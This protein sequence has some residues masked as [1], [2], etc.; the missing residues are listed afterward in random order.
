[1]R[2][3]SSLE[4]MDGWT[5]ETADA[6]IFSVEAPQLDSDHRINVVG[7]A[8][9]D[10]V[11]DLLVRDT[12]HE[13]RLRFPVEVRQPDRAQLIAH[14]M[15]IIG[16]SEAE[17]TVG[18]VRLLDKGTATFLVRYYKGTQ[19]LYGNGTLGVEAATGVVA[20]TPRTFLFEDRDWLQVTPS[21]SMSGNTSLGLLVNGVHFVDVPLISV[22]ASE[23]TSVRI[24]GADESHA[25]KGRQL[26]A[27]AQAYDGASRP[28]W[29]VDYK[30]QLDG[31]TQ[32]GLGDLYR[33]TFDP[34]LPK[35]LSAQFGPLSA[36]AMIH[37][38]QGYVDSSN[39]L[40]CEL[41][42][43]ARGPTAATVAMLLALIA[44]LVRRRLS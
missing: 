35:M 32:S 15:L 43:G 12:S 33:Y 40:G 14:G 17:A 28:V 27:L 21:P 9:K 11:T 42:P 7:H 34:A 3:L 16:R 25:A 1:M 5:V 4:R 41:A 2:S 8:H 24:L 30:W 36:Q 44:I 20:T 39:R 29:G 6:S 10:G 13:L 19:T 23:V 37:T 26:V 22:D 18:D 31:T 38:A